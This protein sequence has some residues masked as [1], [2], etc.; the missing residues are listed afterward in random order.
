[1]E[2]A[3]AVPITY[4]TLHYELQQGVADKGLIDAWNAADTA[5][6]RPANRFRSPED[7]PVWTPTR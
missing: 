2:Q 3:G 5:A 4:K 7:L 6:G 1:M